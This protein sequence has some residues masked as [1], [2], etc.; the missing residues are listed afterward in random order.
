MLNRSIRIF[1]WF[2]K[3]QW[4]MPQSLEISKIKKNKKNFEKFW[5]LIYYRWPKF[6]EVFLIFFY[7][8]NFKWLVMPTY[9]KSLVYQIFPF[10]H[11]VVMNWRKRF[12]FFI[13][14]ISSDCGITHWIFLNQLNILMLRF[15]LSL[16]Y[17]CKL[18]SDDFFHFH[19]VCLWWESEDKSL[20]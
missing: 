16:V 6:F 5:S 15:S 18:W 19:V 11:E 3:I 10:I 7:F 20:L 13:F 14:E 2:R 4:V 12:V 9:G 17:V 8:W 1:N